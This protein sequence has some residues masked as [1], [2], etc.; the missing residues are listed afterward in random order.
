MSG[1]SPSD[2][3][4]IW[5]PKP[6]ERATVV[7]QTGS[8]KTVLNLHLLQSLT[9][10]PVIIYDTKEEPKFEALPH[11]RL[12]F[13]DAELDDAVDDPTVDYA[14][15]R[16][17]VEIIADW[18][19]LDEL[20]Y[21]HYQEFRG[22]DA[23]IDELSEFHAASG[24]HGQGL[25]ALYS[26]GR[27]RGITVIA[28]TQRPAKISPLSLSEAQHIYIFHLNKKNDR[29][30]VSD[31][32]GMPEAPNPPRWHF[33]HWRTDEP[34]MEPQLMAPVPLLRGLESGYTDPT[35]AETDPRPTA[36]LG[37]LWI[38]DRNFWSMLRGDGL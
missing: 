16:P 5:L 21:R 2:G 10:T 15:Y 30:K 27:S 17:S 20:L 32:T 38:G 35:P 37:H 9:T 26:R 11:S 3:L 4:P 1:S 33:W 7:G 29:K 13:E 18:R 6:G 36:D 14:I 24:H 8:G 25:K 19:A 34:D 23:Y 28:S 12:V 22:V 31:D